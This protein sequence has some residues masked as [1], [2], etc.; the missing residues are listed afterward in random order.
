[1]ASCTTHPVSLC[2]DDI[3]SPS[4][5]LQRMTPGDSRVGPMPNHPS[6]KAIRHRDV[7]L[8][9][10]SCLPSGISDTLSVCC[11]EDIFRMSAPGVFRCPLHVCSP[12]SETLFTC[13]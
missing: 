8:M 3:Q 7:S 13:I 6:N 12:V 2:Y 11:H 1:M 10:S 4:G 9:H 5:I